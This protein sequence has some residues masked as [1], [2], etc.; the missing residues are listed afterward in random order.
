MKHVTIKDVAKKLNVSVSSVSKAF[1]DRNDIKKETKEIILKVGKEMGYHPN[2]IAKKLSQQKTFNV[3]VVVP[4][5]INAFFPEVIIGIQ[6]I[7]INKGYQV[8]I[9]QSNESYEMELKNVQVLEE[10]MVDGLIISLSGE[11]KNIDYYKSLIDQNYPIVFFN[12]YND[13]LSASKVVFDDY[14]WSFFV[15]EHLIKQGYKKIFHLSAHQYILLAK[16][17]IRGYKKAMNKYHL[18][19][20]P[21]WIVEAGLTVEEGEMTMQKLIDNNNLPEAIT[22]ATDMLALGVVKCCK[23]NGIKIPDDIALTGFSE[24]PFA[25]LID[26]PLTSVL[27]P[28]YEMGEIAAKLL[29]KQIDNESTIPETVILNGTLNI[30]QSSQKLQNKG[31]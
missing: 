8:L 21:T 2:P 7:L 12:R 28:T 26:P 30:R 19:L 3:G 22:C 27:Q 15:T 13:T 31:E 6:D 11:T 1:N 14:K 24:I 29:L 23:R 10:N 9:M 17:R 20:E 16:E 4:E 18:P 25:E 5:F